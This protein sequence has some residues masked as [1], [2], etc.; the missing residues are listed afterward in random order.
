MHSNVTSKNVSWPHFS[1][2]TLY[3]LYYLL[4]TLNH[5]DKTFLADAVYFCSQ[6]ICLVLAVLEKT[7]L[8]LSLNCITKD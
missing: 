1:W 7:H 8:A 5:N 6:R 3:L 2:T 4:F